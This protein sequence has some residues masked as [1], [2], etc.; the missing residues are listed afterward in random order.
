M[1]FW[2]LSNRWTSQLKSQGREYFVMQLV[3]LHQRI[4]ITLK[5]TLLFSPAC[6]CTWL[7]TAVLSPGTAQPPGF[8]YKKYY[9][10]HRLVYSS[11]YKAASPVSAQAKTVHAHHHSNLLLSYS[12]LQLVPSIP[13]QQQF[14]RIDK[15]TTCSPSNKAVPQL[16][17][18]NGKFVSYEMVQYTP[19]CA[20]REHS[21]LPV[22]ST[23]IEHTTGKR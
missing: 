21:K 20:S 19:L 13:C 10:V 23:Y 2:L 6:V 18:L 8:F 3:P 22:T 9:R 11:Y 17:P 1:G 7:Y 16:V 5:W 15:E 4:V 12:E 14:W